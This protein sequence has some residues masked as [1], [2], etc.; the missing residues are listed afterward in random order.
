MASTQTWAEFNGAGPT[1]TGARAEGNWKAID[2]S[3]TGYASSPVTAGANSMA[4]IQALKFAGTWNTLSALTY[5]VS[6]AA[7]ATGVSVV[8]SVLTSYT[9]PSATATGDSAASTSGTAA[10]FDS[11]TTPFGAGTSSSSAGGTMYANAYRTQ[12]QTTISAGPGDIPTVTITA[13]WTES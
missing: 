9:Q 10:N 3:T 6:S 13:A 7:P 11:S 4:K 8:A 12:M 2:D 5:K 1:E